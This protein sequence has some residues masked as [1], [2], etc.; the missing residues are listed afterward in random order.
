MQ[1]I[2]QLFNFGR[3]SG[4]NSTLTLNYLCT[5]SSVLAEL[6]RNFDQLLSENCDS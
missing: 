4:V 5:T 1:K 6:D 2:V 3:K